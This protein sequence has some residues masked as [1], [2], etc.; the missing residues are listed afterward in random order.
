MSDCVHRHDAQA[1]DVLKL[2]RYMIGT[3]AM[4]LLGDL[5]EPDGALCIL[6]EYD[7][8]TRE[9]IGEWSEGFGFINVRFPAD[10]LREL[11]AEEYSALDGKIRVIGST[12]F[13]GSVGARVRRTNGVD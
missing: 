7:A 8:A 9:Y 10:T 1:D 4:H 5:S 13:P 6:H 3:K 2:P 11:T 12:R